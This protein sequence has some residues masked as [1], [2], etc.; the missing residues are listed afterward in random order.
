MDHAHKTKVNALILAFERETDK[1]NRAGAQEVLDVLITAMEE[2]VEAL[3]RPKRAPVKTPKKAPKTAPS[4][5]ELG[6]QRRI[7]FKEGK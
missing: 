1:K 7:S 4:R 6:D 2:V 5:I 3:P